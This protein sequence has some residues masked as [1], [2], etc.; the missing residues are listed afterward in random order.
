MHHAQRKGIPMKTI[1]SHSTVHVAV[2][3]T[4]L[5]NLV[6]LKQFP[7][8]PFADVIERVAGA[9]RQ[10]GS[11]FVLQEEQ[12]KKKIPKPHYKHNILF[13]DTRI[14]ANSLGELYGKLIDLLFD[15]APEAV[16]KL[17]GMKARTRRF[18]AKD[19]SN[20]HPSS[21]HLPTLKTKSGWHV[22]K[23]IGKVDF[24]RGTRALCT[25]ADIKYGKDVRLQH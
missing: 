11:N 1:K 10:G 4:T 9:F 6:V 25:A 12:A 17:A 8:E 23:N 24:N 21:P 22:S 7:D 19:S 16:E 13:L 15:I 3:E 2:Y 20:I 5:P 14:G 18:V